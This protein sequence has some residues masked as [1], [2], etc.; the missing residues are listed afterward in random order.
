MQYLSLNR[1]KEKF[2]AKK[3]E[4]MDGF[5]GSGEALSIQCPERLCGVLCGLGVLMNGL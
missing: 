1:C 3:K 2:L 5:C 4:V